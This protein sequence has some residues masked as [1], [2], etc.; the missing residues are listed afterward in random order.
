VAIQGLAGIVVEDY[1]P[2][3]V[4][5]GRRLLDRLQANVKQ[6]ERLIRDLLELSRVGRASSRPE[7][8]DVAEIVDDLRV[9]L[10]PALR[11]RGIELVH[12][13]AGVLWGVRM[14]VTQVLSN[15]ISNAAK[16][17]GDQPAPRIEVGS[18]SRGALV[19]TYVKDNGIG[20]DPEYHDK[21]FEIFHRLREVEAE[22]TGVGLTITKKIV[23]SAGG[24]LRIES[25]KGKG[26]TFFFTWPAGPAEQSS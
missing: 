9:E 22:G 8:V 6:M 14:R 23:E 18:R 16:Y 11:A 13:G 10:A 1:A 2:L 24:R 25:E 3:L 19:E 7:A 20:I 12:A 15:L 5:D 17:M 21:I 26:A 4:D